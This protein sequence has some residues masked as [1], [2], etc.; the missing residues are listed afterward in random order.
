MLSS[1]ISSFAQIFDRVGASRTIN[2]FV[3]GAHPTKFFLAN[4]GGEPNLFLAALCALASKAG[5]AK[6][7]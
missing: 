1:K 7:I 6:N 2:P 3:D 5:S 4:L